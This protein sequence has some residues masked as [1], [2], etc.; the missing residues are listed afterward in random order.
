MTIELEEGRIRL[1]GRCGAD[2]AERLLA[3]LAE[4][5]D[6]VDVSGCEHLH[7]ALLQLLIAAGPAIAGEPAPFIAR[8]LVPLIERVPRESGGSDSTA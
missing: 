8:W 4:G 3:L 6:L 7:A 1:S 2:E 5:H